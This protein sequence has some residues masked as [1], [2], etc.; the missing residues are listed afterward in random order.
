MT[1]L[2]TIEANDSIGKKEHQYNQNAPANN[3]HHP[4]SMV[5]IVTRILLVLY[6]NHKNSKDSEK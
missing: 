1:I 6:T 4:T 3:F 5:Q 2:L